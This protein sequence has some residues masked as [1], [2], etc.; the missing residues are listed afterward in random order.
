MQ[1]LL[2][3]SAQVFGTA[4]NYLINT[5]QRAPEHKGQIRAV[6][7]TA[8]QKHNHDIEIFAQPAFTVAAQRDI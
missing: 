7:Q 4:A 3:V 6:P 1:R 8:A 5:V 2:D